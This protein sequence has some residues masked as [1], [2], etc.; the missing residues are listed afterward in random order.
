M[1]VSTRPSA[2]VIILLM[3]AIFPLNSAVTRL[4]S[5]LETAILWFT[6]CDKYNAHKCDVK[7]WTIF[8]TRV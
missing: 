2:P 6:R 4:H 1:V 8:Q 3:A 7:N 5:W